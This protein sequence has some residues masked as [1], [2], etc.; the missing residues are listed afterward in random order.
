M[1]NIE[2]I[3]LT[4]SDPDGLA[5]LLTNVFDW[6]TRWSGESMDNGRTIHIGNPEQSGSYLALYTR[7]NLTDNRD[8]GYKTKGNLNHIGIVVTDLDKVEKK[9][10]QLGIST[11]NHG[12]YEPGRRFYFNISGGLEI[13]VISYS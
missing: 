3:N 13:E 1:N 9:V 6:K 12:E 10:K 7:A 11:F 8:Q 5:E 4:V 2:H